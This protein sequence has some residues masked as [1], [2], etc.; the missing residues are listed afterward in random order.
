MTHLPEIWKAIRSFLDHGRWTS[1]QDVYAHVQAVLPLDAEDDQPQSSGSKV[2]KWKRNT[3]AVFQHRKR[4]GEVEWNG[5]A[6][7][8]LP[9]PDLVRRDDQE[10]FQEFSLPDEILPTEPLLEGAVCRII[11]NAFER[12][13]V[14]RRQCIAA[15]G[16]SCCICHF[17]FGSAYGA[18]AD[19][20]IHVHHVKPLSAI[21]SQH[22]VDPIKDL[23]PVCP[24][25][26]AVLHL[27]GRCRSIE[28]VQSLVQSRQLV[29]RRK[30]KI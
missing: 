15:W 28:E 3:R 13:A 23:R 11:V 8:K 2:P 29:T 7:Y 18:E 30:T 22:F 6:K 16:V 27:G 10:V 17:D 1:L 14:A 21:G 19:G 9:V 12:N 25:C 26:H 20:Y 5:K 24:N 4:T